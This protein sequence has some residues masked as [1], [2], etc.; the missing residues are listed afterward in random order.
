MLPL[1][2][3][4]TRRVSSHNGTRSQIISSLNHK[5]K[6]ILWTIAIDLGSF[7][8]LLTLNL[9]LIFIPKCCCRKELKLFKL[10]KSF[11]F[12][13]GLC[14][15]LIMWLLIRAT[16]L[17]FLSC[18]LFYPHRRSLCVTTST[19]PF[20]AQAE[21]KSHLPPSSAHGR[22]DRLPSAGQQ[23]KTQSQ[24]NPLTRGFGIFTII[25][26]KSIINPSISIYP[27]HKRIYHYTQRNVYWNIRQS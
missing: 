9:Y 19:H 22:T 16:W 23:K 11:K 20:P 1:A 15:L 17:R 5:K 13:V 4:E 2:H 25:S 26:P 12:S 24:G 21:E 6:N 18:S 14:N 3:N 27:F 8:K 10:K 7:L